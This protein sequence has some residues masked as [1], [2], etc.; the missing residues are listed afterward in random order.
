[1]EWLRRFLYVQSLSIV[2]VAQ[3][4]ITQRALDVQCTY[5]VRTVGTMYVQCTYIVRPVPAGK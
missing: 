4:V 5:I 1:M 3:L 2:L